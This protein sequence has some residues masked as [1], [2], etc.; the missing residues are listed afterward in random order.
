[1][2]SLLSPA[3]TD[4]IFIVRWIKYI[5]V[6]V[7]DDMKRYLMVI[8]IAGSILLW[9][10]IK[11]FS[12][13]D[14]R[15]MSSEFEHNCDFSK[16]K[17]LRISIEGK[18]IKKEIKPEYPQDAKLRGIE[19]QVVV[20]VLVDPDGQVRQACAISGDRL[21]RKNAEKAALGFVFEPLLLNEKKLS[22]LLVEQIVFEFKLSGK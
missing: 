19:G 12:N 7:K 8:V 17:P 21:L 22:R 4:C 14:Q 20:K 11:L 10:P 18:R 16:F 6:G 9:H 2:R 1:M 13:Q 5:Y 15:E 3:Y